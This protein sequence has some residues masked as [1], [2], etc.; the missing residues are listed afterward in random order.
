MYTWLNECLAVYEFYICVYESHPFL[1]FSLS[2]FFSSFV[3]VC[4]CV[5]VCVCMGG[6]GTLL[7]LFT[8][9]FIISADTLDQRLKNIETSL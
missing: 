6:L 1:F 3:F 8:S 5:C 4:E 7:S 2:L 9:V